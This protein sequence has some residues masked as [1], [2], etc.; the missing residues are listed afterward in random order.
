MYIEMRTFVGD[1]GG[2]L[3]Y[4]LF[5]RMTEYASAGTGVL[6]PEC[7]MCGHHE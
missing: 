4:A 3:S 5:L 2:S 6:E 1:F 7:G